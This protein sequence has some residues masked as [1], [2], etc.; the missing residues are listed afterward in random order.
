MLQY[1]MIAW[2]V[3]THNI[4]WGLYNVAF[5]LFLGLMWEGL[6]LSS[7]L[8]RFVSCEDGLS[9]DILELWSHCRM[10]HV[11]MVVLMT[12]AAGAI[13]K[14]TFCRLLCPFH[15]RGFFFVYGIFGFK[16]T[17]HD[18]LTNLKNWSYWLLLPLSQPCSLRS[19]FE[20]PALE[21]ITWHLNIS[22]GINFWNDGMNT[23]KLS[24]L[25]A[26]QRL[27]NI[28]VPTLS[29]QFI[30]LNCCSLINKSYCREAVVGIISEKCSFNFWRL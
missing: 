3:L 23:V 8:H 26:L 14:G 25:R 21:I 29:C 1:Q 10:N 6:A 28:H 9:Q 20:K 17:W 22:C 11:G 30:S 15:I 16:H 4:V 7:S 13:T 19:I 24:C 27:W 18:L 12:I 5:L 2:Y